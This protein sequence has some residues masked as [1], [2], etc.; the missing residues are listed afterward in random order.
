MKAFILQLDL[1]RPEQALVVGVYN[2]KYPAQEE[3]KKY[4]ALHPDKI[5][6][7]YEWVAGYTSET[8]VQVVTQYYAPELPPTVVEPASLD[9]TLD[10]IARTETP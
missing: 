2:N 7:V 3:A 10:D 6:G 5:V 1:E 4:I 8:Q 9:S